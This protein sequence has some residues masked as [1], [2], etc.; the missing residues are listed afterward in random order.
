MASL[1]MA[2]VDRSERKKHQHLLV[3]PHR[4]PR[5]YLLYALSPPYGTLHENEAHIIATHHG[6]AVTTL[7]VCVATLLCLRHAYRTSW[8]EL[9]RQYSV[10]RD[11]TRITASG[12]IDDITSDTLSKQACIKYRAVQ[13]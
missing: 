10:K 11:V 9:T 7:P 8:N 6:N 4:A 13:K 1:N 12:I 5:I 2:G 3:I